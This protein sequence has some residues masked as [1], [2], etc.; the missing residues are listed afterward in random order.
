MVR[1]P[2]ELICPIGPD[3]A[4]HEIRKAYLSV[5]NHRVIDPQWAQPTP[6][7]SPQLLVKTYLRSYHLLQSGNRLAAERWARAAKHLGQ[8][9]HHE[10][11]IALLEKNTETIPYL[12][13]AHGQ[14]YG[15]YER[16]DTTTDLLNSVTLRVSE[17]PATIQEEMEPYLNR[18]QEIL[19]N[20]DKNRE[21]H[22]L[23]KAE[24]IQAAHEY[25]RTLECLVL[26]YEAEQKPKPE[27]A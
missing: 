26:A 3:N 8:A 16:S 9:L 2:S 13:G 5:I 22:E 18:A 6:V 20:L 4:E 21:S 10:A 23:L 15:L 19:R 17:Q 25:G 1:K 7:M 11:K 24:R 27:A 14:D 12:T